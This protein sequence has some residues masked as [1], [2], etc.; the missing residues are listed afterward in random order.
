MDVTP[1][2]KKKN[3]MLRPY[4]KFNEQYKIVKV[5]YSP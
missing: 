1:Y 4:L 2:P 3:P 5:V